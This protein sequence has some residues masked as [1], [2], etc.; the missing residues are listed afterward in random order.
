MRKAKLQTAQ[1]TKKKNERDT[2]EAEGKRNVHTLKTLRVTPSDKGGKNLAGK[3]LQSL[4][5]SADSRQKFHV[6]RGV[7]KFQRHK[8]WA[9]VARIVFFFFGYIPVYICI[10]HVC[11]MSHELANP[12]RR[13]MY[14]FKSQL[15][16]TGW[17][18]PIGCLKS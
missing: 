9:Q 18:R 8:P 14:L 10:L 2:Q 13:F 11:D 17:R 15:A 5:H 1:Q 7:Y 16:T 3:L 12:G 6:A 4:V